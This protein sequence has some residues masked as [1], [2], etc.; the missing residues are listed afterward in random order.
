MNTD[1]KHQRGVLVFLW[2]VAFGLP[3]LTVLHASAR[4]PA[5]LAQGNGVPTA[6]LFRGSEPATICVATFNIRRGKGMDGVRDLKRTAKTLQG[7]DIVGLNEVSGGEPDQAQRLGELLGMGYMFAPAERRWYRDDYGNGFLSRFRVGDWRREP[8]R[9]R[10]SLLHATVVVGKEVVIPVL[11]THLRVGTPDGS[12]GPVLESFKQHERA[13][14]MGD[15][16][17][18]GDSPLLRE[19]ID[20]GEALDAIHASVK[21]DDPGKRVDWILTRGLRIVAGG[22]IDLGASDHP[23]YWVELA[24]R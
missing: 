10:R 3:G 14:F 7:F 21:D 19:L 17:A 11:L 18:R 8:L 23:C 15:L 9:G 16:N 5:D 22:R 2:A 4:R 12:L 6:G 1:P 13:I 20:S 24:V